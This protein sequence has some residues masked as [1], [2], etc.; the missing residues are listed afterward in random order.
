MVKR[1]SASVSATRVALV[2]V[3]VTVTVAPGIAPLVPSTTWPLIPEEADSWAPSPAV[4]RTR[5]SR[6]RLA[7]LQLIVPPLPRGFT[8]ANEGAQEKSRWRRWFGTAK[9]AGCDGRPKDC[10]YRAIQGVGWRIVERAALRSAQ[11][12]GTR[13][14][15]PVRGSAFWVLV[16]VPGSDDPVSVGAWW[17]VARRRNR[18][19]RACRPARRH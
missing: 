9:R 12:A 8:A 16:L 3:L 18:M 1:P 7:S 15:R 10:G 4:S 11:R 5:P 2:P 17:R 13:S 6:V 19:R 14:A